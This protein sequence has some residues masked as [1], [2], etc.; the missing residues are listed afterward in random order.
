M[1]NDKNDIW[2]DREIELTDVIGR[3]INDGIR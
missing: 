3:F 2:D 1:V